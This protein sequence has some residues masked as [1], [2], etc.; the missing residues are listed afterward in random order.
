MLGNGKYVRNLYNV[1][2]SSPLVIN[3]VLNNLIEILTDK[4]NYNYLVSLK[5]IVVN[6][7][8]TCTVCTTGVPM[9]TA[10]DKPL[11]LPCSRQVC[12]C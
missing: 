9:E 6:C 10:N 3:L 8:I 1:Y 7:S 11:S 4:D 12:D 2:T 5:Y